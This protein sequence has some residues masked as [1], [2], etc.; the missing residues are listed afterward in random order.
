MKCRQLFM[1]ICLFP[2]LPNIWLKT[3]GCLFTVSDDR[4]SDDLLILKD[5]LRLICITE[6]SQQ[7]QQILI[8]CLFVDKLI[9]SA[10]RLRDAPELALTHALF[11][12]VDELI[13]Y[14]TLLE[15]ALRLFCI[16]ALF[17]SENLNIHALHSSYTIFV[18]QSSRFHTSSATS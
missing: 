10:D 12:H 6:I 16:E 3:D 18:V 5:L 2:F 4:S 1:C 7:C 13:F 8:L 17:C 15:P 11:L 14:A 9:S